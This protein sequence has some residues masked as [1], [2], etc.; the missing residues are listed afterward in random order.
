MYWWYRIEAE[1]VVLHT[2]RGTRVGPGNFLG[3]IV[4]HSK[5]HSGILLDIQ[6]NSSVT[7]ESSCNLSEKKIP[8]LKSI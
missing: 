8:S 7:L 5:A 3:L 2:V 1:P 4:P 6:W